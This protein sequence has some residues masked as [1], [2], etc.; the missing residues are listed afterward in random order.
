[1]WHIDTFENWDHNLS[2]FQLVFTYGGWERPTTAGR[3]G[4]LRCHL[5]IL[6]SF[7]SLTFSLDVGVSLVG[8]AWELSWFSCMCQRLRGSKVPP[9]GSYWSQLML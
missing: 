8:Y 3:M 5:M 1:M 6:T 7:D 2:D 9:N 4:K